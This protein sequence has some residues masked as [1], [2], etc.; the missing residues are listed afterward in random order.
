MAWY[1]QL[2]VENRQWDTH[3]TVYLAGCKH[4]QVEP[5]ERIMR[6]VA[7]SEHKKNPQEQTMMDGWT[8]TKAPQWS[9]EGLMEHIIELVVVDDQVRNAKFFYVTTQTT[10]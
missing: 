6:K 9:R 4:E 3:K 7:E 10:W 5:N 1:Q 2:T 8:V